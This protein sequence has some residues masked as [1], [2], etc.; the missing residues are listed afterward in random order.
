MTELTG[1]VGLAQLDRL[2][3]ICAVRNR[4][5][6]ELTRRIKNL[7]GIDPPAVLEGG[8]SSYWFYMFRINEKEA[9]V[10]RDEFSR[11]LG[12]EGI[13]NSPGYIPTCVY[14]YD[15]FQN[16]SAFPGSGIPFDIN[17]EKDEIDYGRG[18]CPWPRTSSGRPSG[19][20]SANFIPS[21]I[22]AKWPTRSSRWRDITR[23]G[24]K[25][26]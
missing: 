12:A 22:C 5:G 24:G 6:D 25:K 2:Q 17:H 21:R 10:S 18:L 16:R 15:L 7:P 3:E 8:K 19:F 1:A 11:A 23:K 13:P 14:E 20:P 4:Y 9:G 26:I